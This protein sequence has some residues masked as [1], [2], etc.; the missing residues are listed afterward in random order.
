MPKAMRL[1]FEPDIGPGGNCGFSLMKESANAVGNLRKG[2]QQMSVWPCALFISTFPLFL[3]GVSYIACRQVPRFPSPRQKRE[4]KKE[5]KKNKSCR[6]VI[7]TSTITKK[8]KAQISYSHTTETGH[9]K[10]V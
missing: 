4:V 8:T 7:R 6:L 3:G 5:G 2:V 1:I 10:L 9:G